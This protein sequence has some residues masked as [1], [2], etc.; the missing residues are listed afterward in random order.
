MPGKKSRKSGKRSKKL[1]VLC[2][3]CGT[4]I[5]PKIHPPNTTWTM[6]SPMPDKNGQITLTIMG[7]FRCPNCG[8]SV[9]AS[10]QKIKGDEAFS[11]KSKK[12]QLLE[13]LQQANSP[14]SVEDI[15]SQ[16]GMSVSVVTKA[17]QKLIS[18]G[19][20]K[21]ALREGKYMP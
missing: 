2:K 20:V 5:D 12:Q 9:K 15:A 14:K 3:K 21:G 19:Q 8:A 6:T 1:K 16:L 17:I 11:G 4:E 10:L 7:S 13:L 18:S